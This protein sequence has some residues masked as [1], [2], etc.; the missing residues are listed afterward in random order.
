M[1]E[2]FCYTTNELDYFKSPSKQSRKLCTV[3]LL[4]GFIFHVSSY[5]VSCMQDT[6]INICVWD[7]EF[8]LATSLAL[9]KGS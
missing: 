3:V 1:I 9:D 2:I 5:D 4:L 6:R 7:C 8:Q